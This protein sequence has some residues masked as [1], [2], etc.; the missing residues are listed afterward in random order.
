MKKLLLCAAVFG[1][2][3][4]AFPRLMGRDHSILHVSPEMQ[5]QARQLSMSE[6]NC[7]PTPCGV[8]G[9]ADQ[10]AN[11]S[12]G[13]AHQYVAPGPGDIRGPCPGLNAAAN[14]GFLPHNGIPGITQNK[15][16]LFSELYMFIH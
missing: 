15:N 2:A 11:V 13:S 6:D 12:R 16:N 9:E 8:L 4:N 7:G 5:I 3:V 10:F 14:H 1:S